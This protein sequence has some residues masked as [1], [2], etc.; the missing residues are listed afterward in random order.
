MV[1]KVGDNDILVS[2]SIF[3]VD[4]RVPKVRVGV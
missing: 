4:L 3:G 1:N 2:F